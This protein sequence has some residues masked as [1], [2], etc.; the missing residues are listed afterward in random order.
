[1][2]FQQFATLLAGDPADL[3]AAAFA[4]Q[5]PLTAGQVVAAVDLPE[6]QAAAA[7]AELLAQGRVFA[8]EE[9]PGSPLI[10]TSGWLLLHQ[11]LQEA[12]TLYHEANPLRQGMPREEAKSRLQPRAGWSA[13]LFNAIVARAVAEGAVS[14]RAALLALPDFAVRYSPAQQRGIDHLLAQFRAAAFTPPSVKQCLEVVEEE[15]FNA[16]LE[17]G[18]LIR[19]AP[20]VVF[21]HATY[22]H[23]VETVRK[24]IAAHG[25]MTVADARDLFDTSRKYALALLEYLDQIRI[26]RREGDARV[27][28]N[29]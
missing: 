15:V 28:R 23:M 14:E 8:L 18:T 22:E 17:A 4:R 5:G 10:T 9:A 2:L 3:L 12:L 1:A 24:H 11:A 20:D 29:A 26:T 6:D 21:A 19:V 27:M 7:L 16:L 25:Q 13:R